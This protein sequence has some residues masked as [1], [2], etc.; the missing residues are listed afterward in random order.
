[1]YEKKTL[2]LMNDR[3]Y[4]ISGR[5][6]GHL[7]AIEIA[8][9]RGKRTYWRC[10]CDCGKECLVSRENL[11]TGK[12][13]SCGHL[14]ADSISR[15]RAHGDG[16]K[17]V[18]TEKQEAWLLKHF[19]HTKNA[20]IMSK[21]GLSEGW[22]HRY[23]RAHGLKKTAQFMNKTQA[24]VTRKAKESHLRNGTYPPKGYRI[25]RSEEF[26]FKPGE[27]SVQRLGKRRERVRIEK[28][29]KTRAH[30]FQIEKATAHWGL[31][32]LTKLNVTAQ[33]VA[34]NQQRYHLRKLGYIIARGSSIAYYDENTRRSPSI[35]NRKLGD[36]HY[37]HFEF[38]RNTEE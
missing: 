34:K 15:V 6:Y 21:L 5:Q 37:F 17:K 20:E 10:L 9:R 19:C 36:K 14:R 25:P 23:A 38:I 2:K 30:T 7:T 32:Q 28:S 4:D 29:A 1:M 27:K 24:E 22:L 3:I 35:E 26:Q 31:P 33:P 16:H 13:Q 18:L 11:S 12:T 8:E